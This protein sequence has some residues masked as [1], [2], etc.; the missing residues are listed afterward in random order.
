MYR[1]P[2]VKHSEVIAAGADAQ[3]AR[4]QLEELNTKLRKTALELEAASAKV[5]QLQI[6]CKEAKGDQ[7]GLQVREVWTGWWQSVSGRKQPWL[8]SSNML[9]DQR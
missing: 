7:D 8:S 3:E 5:Q 1:L 9:Y 6:A 2:Q 4:S